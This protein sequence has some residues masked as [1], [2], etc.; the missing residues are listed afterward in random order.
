MCIKKFKLILLSTLYFFSLSILNAQT[1]NN[2]NTSLKFVT[3][4]LPP[5]GWIDKQGKPHGI[6]Y[7]L[8][9]EIA[10]RSGLPYT[11][12]IRPF[13]RML[14]EL[15]IGKADLISSQ[16]HKQSLEAG[17]KLEIQ[18]YIDVITVTK[19]DSNIQTI[20]D[21]KNKNLIY[22]H[23]ASYKQLEGLPNKITYI[24]GYKESLITLYNRQGLDAAVFSEPAYYFWKKNLRLSS[25]DFG[26]V[27]T[28]EK[29]KEQW[30]FVRKD[31]PNEI[32]TKLK[33]IVE[34][35][36]NEG[37]YDSLLKKYGKD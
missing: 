15:K 36:R 23:N 6:I 30:I 5:Y 19:K 22:H 17:D 16:A 14:T 24:R 13:P 12:K 37:L 27:L 26:K 18:H 1:S 28:I 4:D 21:L 7:E 31:L 29:N 33:K 25:K 11:H 34:D 32:R 9:E 8:T 10:K 20:K 35:I 3:M 2:Q